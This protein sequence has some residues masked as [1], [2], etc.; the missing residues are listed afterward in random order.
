MV[1]STQNKQWAEDTNKFGYV[2]L[3]KMGWEKDAGLGKD[4]QGMVDHIRVRK[5]IDVAGGIGHERDHFGN[6]IITANLSAFEEVLASLQPTTK[7]TKKKKNNKK[8]KSEK[9]EDQVQQEVKC[10]EERKKRVRSLSTCSLDSLVIIKRKKKKPAK[11]VKKKKTKQVDSDSSSDSDSESK[12]HTK[13]VIKRLSK[14]KVSSYSKADL[15]AILG[16]PM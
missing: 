2:M 11:K 9:S 6:K 5:K 10:L 3:Q 14:K 8:K 7:K 4:G 16:Q 13:I 1:K 15:A 12:T